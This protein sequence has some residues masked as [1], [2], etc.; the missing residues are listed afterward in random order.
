MAEEKVAEDM[1]AKE[2][3]AEKKYKKKLNKMIERISQ[4]ARKMGL[5][6]GYDTIDIAADSTYC[7]EH[8]TLWYDIDKLLTRIFTQL[9]TRQTE[10]RGRTTDNPKESESPMGTDEAEEFKKTA[11]GTMHLMETLVADICRAEIK[12]ERSKQGQSSCTMMI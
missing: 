10:I 1:L 9:E 8:A 5:G 11:S 3:L 7:G 6:E 4:Q 2:K 12:V